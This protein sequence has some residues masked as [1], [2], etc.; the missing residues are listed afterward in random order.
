VLLITP[1]Y[2]FS[3]VIVRP[4]SNYFSRGVHVVRWRAD[5]LLVVG[6]LVVSIV[7]IVGVLVASIDWLHLLDGQYILCSKTIIFYK[8]TVSFINPLY[9]GYT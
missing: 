5:V 9:I 8:P 2:R 1:K 4:I 7:C 3:L 6:V